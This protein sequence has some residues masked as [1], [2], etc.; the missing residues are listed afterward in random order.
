VHVIGDSISVMSAPLYKQQA[1]P[2]A[3]IDAANGRCVTTL[4]SRI[5]ARLAAGP[6]PKL[7]VLA[8]GT[9][10]CGMTITRAQFV[11]A[12]DLIPRKSRVILVTPWVATPPQ[13]EARAAEELTVE[14]WMKDLDRHRP[15]AAIASWAWTM[16]SVPGAAERY[17]QPDGVHPT[18]EGTQKWADLVRAAES[19]F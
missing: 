8:L 17:I 19:R 16:R 13:P 18:P 12:F 2:S 7:W 9:N 14:R 11:A 5:R 15:N 10:T 4:R 1:H 6:S 3:D